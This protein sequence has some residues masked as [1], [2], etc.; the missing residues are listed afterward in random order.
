MSVCCCWSMWTEI[1]DTLWSLQRALK[2][3]WCSGGFV[4]CV[5]VTGHMN[6]LWFE[7]IVRKPQNWSFQ[8]SRRSLH[9]ST[10]AP[11][12]HQIQLH[13]SWD[14]HL[15]NKQVITSFNTLDSM[16]FHFSNYSRSPGGGRADGQ[17][18]WTEDIWKSST[19]THARAHAHTLKQT[20]Q[21]INDQPWQH[22]ACKL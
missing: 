4:G 18:T 17:M 12:L 9:C 21:W 14:I 19:H 15:A 1:C 11:A 16:A 2:H 8:T 5:G 22:T 10:C 13:L 7:M 3:W 20:Q 6:L